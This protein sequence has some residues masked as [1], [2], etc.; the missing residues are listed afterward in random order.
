M[1]S[2]IDD[3]RY[4]IEIIPPKQNTEDIEGD[5]EK[6]AEKYTRVIEDGY[7]ICL[8]DNAMGRKA[9]QG[10]EM[11][12][13]LELPVNPDQ[14]MLHLNTFHSKAN[15]DEILNTAKDLGI[16]YILVVSGDG[17]PDMSR[18]EPKDIGIDCVTVTSVELC[19]YIR[20]NYPDFILGVAF[21][22]YE[23]PEAE[24]AKMER[25]LAAGASFIITQPILGKNEV[26]DQLLA[27]YP[28]IPTIAEAWMSK[29]AYLLSDVVGYEIPTDA[30]YDG[31]ATLKELVKNYPQC[32]FYLSLIGYKTQYPLIGEIWK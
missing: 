3:K 15:L 20:A 16:K 21:N 30:D 9:F 27:K 25:K 22:P 12:T 13:E 5:L 32:G 24:F 19:K 31:I 7:C 4:H 2:H 8:T 18:L 1:K 11:I 28:E 29:K 23:P 10:T 6:F 14:V 26:F 17:A